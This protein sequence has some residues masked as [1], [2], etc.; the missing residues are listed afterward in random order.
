M[1]MGGGSGV[2]GHTHFVLK[3][4]ETKTLYQGQCLG[5][6]SLKLCVSRNKV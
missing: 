1:V 3:Y 2:H 5:L 6:I 4:S